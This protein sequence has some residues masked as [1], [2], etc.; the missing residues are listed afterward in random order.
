MTVE[1]KIS[2]RLALNAGEVRDAILSHLASKDFPVPASYA[3]ACMTL[4][5]YGAVI[6]WDEQNEINI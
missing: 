4:G 3:D 6:E 2:R 5:P 1:R